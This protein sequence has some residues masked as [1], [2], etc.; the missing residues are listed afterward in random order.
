MARS[1][2]TSPSAITSGASTTSGMSAASVPRWTGRSGV[3][4]LNSSWRSAVLF[5]SEPCLS[6]GVSAG[7]PAAP[8]WA[9]ESLGTRP[10]PP[11]S[12]PSIVSRP[13]SFSPRTSAV[14]GVGWRTPLIGTYSTP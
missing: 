1:S 6:Q 11:S 7:R 5:W 9:L 13:V 4:Q 12:A 2:Y 14:V 3:S 8:T 10:S